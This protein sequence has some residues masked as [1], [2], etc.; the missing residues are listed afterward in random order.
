MA[1]MMGGIFVSL[2]M[3]FS[4]AI[5][6]SC[7]N[8]SPDKKDDLVVIQNSEIAKTAPKKIVHVKLRRSFKGEYSWDLTGDDVK[9]ILKINRELKKEFPQN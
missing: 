4:M 3:V 8:A 6:A 9:E 7:A 2:A 5:M 1:A